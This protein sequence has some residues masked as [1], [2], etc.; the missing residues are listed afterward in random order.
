MMKYNAYH[1]PLHVELIEECDFPES[2]T[3]QI[4]WCSVRDLITKYASGYNMDSFANATAFD[5]NP[6]TAVRIPQGA[7]LTD[8][9]NIANQE[10]Q[11]LSER[12]SEE[13]KRTESDNSGQSDS[14][15]AGK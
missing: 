11:R 5:D 1:N 15:P 2:E 10:A 3:K 12:V 8:L 7:D 6:L 13:A 14:E 4:G 9:N